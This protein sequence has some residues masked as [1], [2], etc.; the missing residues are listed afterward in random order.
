VSRIAIV[1]TDTAFALLVMLPK[2]PVTRT[3]VMVR[4]ANLDFLID[5]T[6]P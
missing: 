4:I 1:G 6:T 5:I 3:I 2:S